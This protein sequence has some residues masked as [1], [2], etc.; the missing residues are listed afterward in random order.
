MGSN[1]IDNS[2]ML[3]AECI[4]VVSSICTKFEEWTSE[5]AMNSNKHLHYETLSLLSSATEGATSVQSHLPWNKAAF[6]I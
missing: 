1:M 5:C 4:Q 3:A 2:V 6:L